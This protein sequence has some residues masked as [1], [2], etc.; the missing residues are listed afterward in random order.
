MK[1]NVGKRDVPAWCPFAPEG[2]SLGNHDWRPTYNDTDGP[3]AMCTRCLL[4]LD[5]HEIYP[6][7]KATVEPTP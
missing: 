2:I 6:F 7:Y 1:V 5:D 3:G 4:Y